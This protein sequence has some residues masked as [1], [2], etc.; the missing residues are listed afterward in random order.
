MCRRQGVTR[1]IKAELIWLCRV[2]EFASKL[3]RYK[4][5]LCKVYTHWRTTYP[6]T[7][8]WSSDYI[9]LISARD[10][11]GFGPG[12]GRTRVCNLY[13][14]GCWVLVG[15]MFSSVECE[16]DT[17]D[18]IKRARMHSGRYRICI[19]IQHAGTHFTED[20][21]G[22]WTIERAAQHAVST[23]TD[24]WIWTD[25]SDFEPSL[26]ATDG[27]ELEASRHRLA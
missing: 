10:V 15:W 23:A 25:W 3:T 27:L 18:G 11:C 5:T 9:V 12:L 2:G 13:L 6:A 21:N 22:V 17:S 26:A 4:A 24:E 14:N 8:M 7:T 1:A 16:T 20:L 19:Y